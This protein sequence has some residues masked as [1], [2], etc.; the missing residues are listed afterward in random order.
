ML[1]LAAFALLAQ[2]WTYVPDQGFVD[3]STMERRSGTELLDQAEAAR[4]KGRL[5]EALAAFLAVAAQAPEPALRERGLW[6]AGRTRMD[7][8]EFYEAYH[9]FREFVIRFPQSPRAQEA[10]R[11]EMTSALELARKGHKKAV[12]GVRI[13]ST[14]ETGIEYLRES[15]RRYPREDF[16]ADFVQRLGMY[17]YRQGELDLAAAEFQHVLDQYPDAPEVVLAIYML[18]MTAEQR[19]DGIERDAKPLRDARRL[20]ERFL[21][22]SGRMRRLPDPAPRWVDDVSGT[23]RERLALVYGRLH[24]KTLLSAEYYD[25]KDLPRSAR[26][27]YVSIL[28][29]EASFRRVLPDFPE[30]PAVRRARK[31]V[32]EAS[33]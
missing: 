20:Y 21:E 8:E 19:F 16:A 29:D 17:F 6:E 15:L 12:L 14:P 27:Y 1:A 33:K 10:K 18:G 2:D 26:F 4:E 32:S 13:F 28:R 5:D 24:E 9:A 25:G 3:R 7:A 11:L 23:V 22:E 31:R 30:H